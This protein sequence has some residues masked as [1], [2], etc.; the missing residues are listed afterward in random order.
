MN[1]IKVLLIDSD[2][3]VFKAL[4]SKLQK[5]KIDLYHAGDIQT[6]MYRFE[7]QYFNVVLVDSH[8]PELD[9]LAIIQKFQNHE[10]EDK[11]N[12]WGLL[13][14]STNVSKEQQLLLEELGGISQIQKPFNH[15]TFGSL[16]Q[17]ANSSQIQ[18]SLARKLR[19]SILH[20]YKVTGD[21]KA[22]MSETNQS[23]SALGSEYYPLILKLLDEASAEETLKFLNT[24]PNGAMSPIKVLS[25]K[26]D[27]YLKTGN[28]QKAREAY[29]KAN[30]LAPQNLDRLKS[31]VDVYLESKLPEKARET[32]KKLIDL[33]P[34]NPDLKF[35]FFNQLCEHG[36]EDI[37]SQ[38]CQEVS[39]PLEV[40]KF[41]NNMGVVHIKSGEI[42]TSF[43][44]YKRALA[45]YPNNPK[46][47]LIHFNIAL[48]H[49]KNKGSHNRLESATEHLEKALAINPKYDKAIELLQKVRSVGSAA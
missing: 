43:E 20:Q 13:A 24:I 2:I 9:G 6:A 33:S 45:L 29:E 11:R 14:I 47:Y 37:A 39:A 16:I 28:L 34:E 25:L 36:F 4:E 32:Q 31:L 10:V 17:K 7:K 21:V 18:R 15:A 3:S 46:N 41:Y 22:A 23:K 5:Q 48:A 1:A 38:F 12:F 27:V 19:D 49:L 40:V 35:D 44:E 8:F 30:E 26:G 42:D